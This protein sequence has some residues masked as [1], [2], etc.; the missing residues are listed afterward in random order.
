[1]TYVTGEELRIE[2]TVL[3]EVGSDRLR[4]SYRVI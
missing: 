3:P 1:M 4:V 2:Y